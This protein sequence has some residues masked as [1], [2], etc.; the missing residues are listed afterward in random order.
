MKK[1]FLLL[2]LLVS[3]LGFSQTPKA[4]FAV[5]VDKLSDTEYQITYDVDIVPNWR[6]YS[7]VLP[8]MTALPTEFIYLN[9]DGNY[10]VGKIEE[11]GSSIKYDPIFQA[12]MG[13]FE[14]NAKFTQKIELTNFDTEFIEVDID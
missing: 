13:Y 12:E 3:F 6:L 9:E 4:T 8:D 11:F 1:I 7:T 2:T 10:T 14:N 5:S